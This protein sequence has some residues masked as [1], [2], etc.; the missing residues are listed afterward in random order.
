M[1]SRAIAFDPHS[2]RS[3]SQVNKGAL[4]LPRKRKHGLSDLFSLSHSTAV[5]VLTVTHNLAQGVMGVQ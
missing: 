1:R 3:G 5:L 2:H 4:I